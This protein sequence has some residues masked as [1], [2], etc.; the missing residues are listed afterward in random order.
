VWG[1]GAP[2]VSALLSFFLPLTAL[3]LRVFEQ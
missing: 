1:V 3:N 2:L